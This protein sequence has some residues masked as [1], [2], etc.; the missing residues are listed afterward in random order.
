MDNWLLPYSIDLALGDRAA[1]S[2]INGALALYGDNKAHTWEITV[3]MDKEPADLSDASAMAYFVRE[4]GNTV[5][6]TGTVIGSVCTYVMLPSC[7]AVKGSL[8]CVLKIL[9]AS[10]GPVTL[11]DKIVQIRE[12]VGSS[13]VDP[14]AVIPN[15]DTLIQAAVSATQAANSANTAASTAN[16]AAE[17]AMQSRFTVLGIYPTLADLQTA[18]PTGTAGGRICR[19]HR[20]LRG[21]LHMECRYKRLGEYRQHPD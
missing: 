5:L 11:M 16:E 8:R 14:G 20:Q 15:I 6:V 3:L 10:L 17:Y 2:L 21:D 12:G 4:D 19:R 7:Y 9:S 18:H 1:S 13:F